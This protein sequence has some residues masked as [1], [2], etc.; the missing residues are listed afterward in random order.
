MKLWSNTLPLEGCTGPTSTHPAR[1]RILVVDDESDAL[2]ALAILLSD[3]HDVITADDGLE[4]LEAALS[5]PHPDLVITDVA[6]PGID[7]VTM[8]RRM[9]Q[10]DDLRRVPVIFLTGQSSVQCVVSGISAGARAYLIKPIDPDVL[11]RKVRSALAR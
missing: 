10:Y 5:D 9:K 7:G 3:E 2:R 8:V 1:K 6:M 11:E 4:G